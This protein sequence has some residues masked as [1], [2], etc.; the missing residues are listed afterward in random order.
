MHLVGAQHHEVGGLLDLVALRVDVGHAGGAPA[1]GRHVH[2]L[3]VRAGSQFKVGTLHQRRQ[4]RGLRRSLRVHVAAIALA[5]AAEVAGAELRAMRVG[6]GPRSI[7]RGLREGVVAQLARRLLEEHGAVGRCQRRQRV[8]VGA[9]ALEGVASGLDLALEVAGLARGAADLLE[10][11]EVRLEFVV[12]DAEVL[13][14][15]AFG[16]ELLAVARFIGAAQLQVGRQ[17]APVVAIPVHTGA[18]D[19]IAQQEG[20][21]LP[22]RHRH[23][24]RRVADGDGLFR[25]VLEQLAA[26]TVAQLVGDARV[27]EVGHGVAVLTALQRQNL[28]A[29]GGEFHAHDGAGPAEADQHRVDAGL[30]DACHAAPLSPAAR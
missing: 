17:R 25:E 19:A 13:Q 18:A 29:R 26:D 21:V 7:G 4:Q 16:D 9:P 1:V 12:G 24:G 11:V 14:V 15:H 27:C 2:A 3:H 30:L 10:H 8:L 5:E 20:A 6:V 22:I 23:V 28:Q